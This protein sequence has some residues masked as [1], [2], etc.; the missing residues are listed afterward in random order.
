V[1][2][3]GVL[4]TTF[5]SFHCK[6]EKALRASRAFHWRKKGPKSPFFFVPL[7]FIKQI[8]LHIGDIGPFVSI[9]H[10]FYMLIVFISFSLILV[11]SFV[12]FLSNLLP[13]SCHA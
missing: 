10:L 6:G 11:N 4:S 9:F 13:Y 7:D 3:L 8:S 2:N 5:L 12:V 1:N